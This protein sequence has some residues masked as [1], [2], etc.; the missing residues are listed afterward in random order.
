MKRLAQFFKALSDTTRLRIIALLSHG[1][2]CVCDLMEVLGEPQSKISRHLTYLKHSEI[3]ESRR[4]GVWMQYR[5][6]ES[7]NGIFKAQIHLLKEK[8]STLPQFRA[9]KE[10]LFE[11]KKRGDCKTVMKLRSTRLL[12]SSKVKTKSV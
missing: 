2:L 1:E 11:L 8:L 7:Q 6:K 9:D 5:L 12:K 3:T 4:V 10:R